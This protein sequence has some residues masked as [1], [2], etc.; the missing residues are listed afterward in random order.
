MATLLDR[1]DLVLADL[2]GTLYQGRAAIPGAVEAVLAAGERGVRTV[3]VTNNASRSPGDVAA[4]LA[5]LGYP[6]GADDVATSS[7]AAA[8]LLAEQLPDGA[9]VLV[10]GTAALAAE[11]TAVGLTPT[12]AA[13]GAT[14][15]VQ[16]LDPQLRYATLAEACIALRAGAAWVACNVDPTLPSERGPLPGNG[17][18]VAV[19]RTA[20]R[21]EPQVAGKPAPALMQTA[22]RRLGASAPLVVGDRLDTDI[23]GGR[24]AGI[25]TLLV[26][27]GVS[28]A[29][30]LL[31]APPEARPDYV[32][33]D[34]GAL[35]LD[36]ANL[37]LGPRP[38]WTVDV[39]S[40][41]LV[42]SG[43]GDPLDALRALCVPHWDSGGGPARVRA[44][45]GDAEA[46]LHALGLA[47]ASGSAT[48]AGADAVPRSS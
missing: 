39:G 7:Q 42:L 4:H 40:G 17:S 18:L 25:P 47:A 11:I 24:A 20:T 48:V 29:V 21:L 44:R 45:G 10:V 9:K 16:G 37:A 36:P 13:A 26:L 8:A 34:L 6:A 2:D 33:T 41:G 14:A 46:A 28:D 38:G 32:G 15:V 3:Y 23:Q 19:L 5:E 31:A 22:A 1:H 30:E 43:S 27:T 35:D 12:D